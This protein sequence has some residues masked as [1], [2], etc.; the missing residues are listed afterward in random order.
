MTEPRSDQ[1]DATASSTAKQTGDEEGDEWV[2][3]DENYDDDDYDDGEEEAE[4]IARRLKEQLWA[5]ISKAQA[6]RVNVTT[7]ASTSTPSAPL[8]DGAPSAVPSPEE[9]ALKTMGNVL[10]IAGKDPLVHSTLASAVVPGAG[11]SVLEILNH[12]VAAGTISKDLAK[13]LSMTL[14]SLARSDALFAALRHSN[15]PALQL[16][17]GKRKRDETEEEQR[18]NE[19][20]AFKRPTFAH[21]HLQSQITD[22]VRVVSETLASHP[23]SNGP[24]DPSIISSIQLQLHQIFLFAVTSSARGGPETNALQEISGLI[25]VVGVL[26]GSPIGPTAVAPNAHMQPPDVS[27]YPPR[28]WIPPGTGPQPVPFSDIGTAVYPCLVPGCRKIFARLFNLRAHQQVHAVHRPYRCAACPASFARNHDLKRH[29]KLHD[30]TGYQCAG[31]YK[32]FSRRDAIKRHK[33][34]SATRGGKGEACVN[35]AIKEVELDKESGD[36][37]LREG[38]RTRMWADI[39]THSVAS[40]TSYGTFGDDWGPE[41][42]EMDVDVIGHAQEAV[43]SLHKTLQ[44][45]VS[46]ALGTAVDHDIPPMQIDPAGSQATLASVIARAQ[47]QNM[48]APQNQQDNSA[49]SAA[50]HITAESQPFP[51]D[52]GCG[53]PNDDYPV[54][55]ADNATVSAPPLSLYGL[56]EE[57]ARLLEQAI[58]NAA[59]AAQAQAEAEAALEE[60]EE[61]YEED[62]DEDDGEET[63]STVGTEVPSTLGQ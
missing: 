56:S 44:S 37:A 8:H 38:R 39:V 63:I 47:L 30:K 14:V 40:T 60:Q 32:L 21:G 54:P 28:P 25:Q 48:P 18:R 12:T 42:G 43:L 46:S 17:K 6:D 49:V 34:S 52:D 61:D 1:I 26:S 13:S 45:H 51:V 11:N 2:E 55:I 50:N 58:A 23:P 36:D 59:S 15:A 24:P 29:A 33:N 10:N 41:E 7:T 57:Q 35:A 31:C 19:P 62:C 20:R 53:V 9:A 3:E 16:D 27:M 4:E 5:D 22:A